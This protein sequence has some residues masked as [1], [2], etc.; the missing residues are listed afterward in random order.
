[1]K[2]EVNRNNTFRNI[3]AEINSPSRLNQGAVW[4]CLIKIAASLKID[5]RNINT[6]I[7]IANLFFFL[8]LNIIFCCYCY[9]CLRY[10]LLQILKII[11][12]ELIDS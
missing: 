10:L 12:K 8:C 1:M 7:V 11:I 6:G 9:P 2:N 5:I 4:S 3:Y